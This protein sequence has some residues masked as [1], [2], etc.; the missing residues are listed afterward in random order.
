MTR[1]ASPQ[2]Y[3]EKINKKYAIRYAIECIN[4]SFIDTTIPLIQT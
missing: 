4:V 3:M 1:N 2:I